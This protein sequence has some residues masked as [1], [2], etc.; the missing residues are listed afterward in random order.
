MRLTITTFLTLDGVMQAPGAPDEDRGGGFAHGGW[1]APYFDDEAGESILGWFARADAFL[2]GRRTYEIFA[3]FWPTVTDPDDP[4]AT[5]LNSKPKYVAS[6]TLTSADWPTS[7]VIADVPDAVRTLKQQPG[8]ELQVHGSGQLA[9][10][11]MAHGLI[12]EYRLLIHPVV[13]GSGRRLFTDPV[14]AALRLVESRTTPSGVLVATYQPAGVP[15]YGS[16]ADH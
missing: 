14:P 10:T 5:R 2:L 7:T 8:N 3:G 9:G 13:L 11:L 15:S 6:R 16:M 1:Q 12:D 4:I